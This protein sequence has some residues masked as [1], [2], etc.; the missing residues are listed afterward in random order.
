M[1]DDLGENIRTM[2]LVN[3]RMIDVED[4]RRE[5]SEEE[6]EEEVKNSGD[7]GISDKSQ[8]DN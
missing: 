6:D 8:Q 1:R 2:R 7:E 5:E 3:N 4:L